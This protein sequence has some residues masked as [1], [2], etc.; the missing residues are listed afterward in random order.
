MSEEAQCLCLC[1]EVGGCLCTIESEDEM[2]QVNEELEFTMC[3][4][5]PSQ[6]RLAKWQRSLIALDNAV[7]WVQDNLDAF[8]EIPSLNFYPDGCGAIICFG[9]LSQHGDMLKAIKATFAGQTA[10]QRLSGSTTNYELIDEA[11]GLKFVWY[12][13]KNESFQNV[14]TEVVL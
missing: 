7:E 10:K 3:D 13:F 11:T 2:D 4:R 12:V 6:K 9:H 1:R 14:E 5:T 8:P